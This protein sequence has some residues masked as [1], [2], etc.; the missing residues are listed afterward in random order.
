MGTDSEVAGSDRT[1]EASASN[2]S[3]AESARAHIPPAAISHDDPADFGDSGVSMGVRP[4]DDS[5]SA[6]W[7]PALSAVDADTCSRIR[8]LLEVRGVSRG[9]IQAIS[10]SWNNP[11]ARRKRGLGSFNPKHARALAAWFSYSD[12]AGSSEQHLHTPPTAMEVVDWLDSLSRGTPLSTH[13]IKGLHVAV[14]ST[15]RL[16]FGDIADTSKSLLLQRWKASQA[17]RRG[18][19]PAVVRPESHM[20]FA[21]LCA[22]IPFDFPCPGAILPSRMVRLIVC[23][24][25]INCHGPRAVD[26]T[27]LPRGPTLPP[28]RLHPET[29]L[30]E[31]GFVVASKKR[32]RIEVSNDGQ[33]RTRAEDFVVHQAP[34]EWAHFSLYT[35]LPVHAHFLHGVPGC[36]QTVSWF[37]NLRNRPPTFKPLS[38]ASLRSWK[39]RYL[40]SPAWIRRTEKGWAD[41]VPA[42]LSSHN[43]RGIVGSALVAQ[44]MSIDRAS[45]LLDVSVDE[46]KKSYLHAVPV[47]S[48]PVLQPSSAMP[49]SYLWAFLP[50]KWALPELLTT[51]LASCD[52]RQHPLE[53]WRGHGSDFDWQGVD[54]EWLARAA[55]DSSLWSDWFQSRLTPLQWDQGLFFDERTL[56]AIA[57]L[58][59]PAVRSFLADSCPRPSWG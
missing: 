41:S 8:R 11:Q 42:I 46:F 16:A 49:D 6:G 25:A 4:G 59:V 34:F 20:S 3:D 39:R 31:R 36:P 7:G 37:P 19:P 54:A 14:N 58:A 48:E 26:L 27:D 30:W 10:E 55:A 13:Q 24:A 32:Q 29:M 50:S 56:A 22:S 53:E 35:W 5:E 47:S 38:V 23:L 40:L 52:R 15:F 57:L 28:L 17:L 21:E 12:R 9:T 51:A 2:D 45:L 33:V 1:A 43:T 18:P 44:G